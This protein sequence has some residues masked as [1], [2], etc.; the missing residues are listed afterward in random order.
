MRRLLI[1]ITI[2][3]GLLLSG[4]NSCTP[5]PPTLVPWFEL[6]DPEVSATSCRLVAYVPE[7]VAG[8]YDYGFYFGP[9]PFQLD[10]YSSENPLY[11]N[12]I[13]VSQNFLQPD[14]EYYYMAYANNG[15]NE[16]CS[17]LMSLRTQPQ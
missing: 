5:Q 4:L 17:E 10:K 8:D 7:E 6:P 1:H 13:A 12:T 2:G 14:T 15:Y 9:S 11:L 16:V 3:A